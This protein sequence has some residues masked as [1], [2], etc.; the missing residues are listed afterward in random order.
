MI[1]ANGS[2]IQS[3]NTTH[4]LSI[5]TSKYEGESPRFIA[6]IGKI[7]SICRGKNKDS[8]QYTGI[9]V[10]TIDIYSPKFI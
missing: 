9:T 10:A 7:I 5:L 6:Y 3:V 8:Q 4:I 1:K 2:K